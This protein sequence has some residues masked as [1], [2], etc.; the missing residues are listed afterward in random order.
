MYTVNIIDCPKSP[1][2]GVLGSEKHAAGEKKSYNLDFTFDTP[3]VLL[4][5]Q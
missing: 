3:S 5:S 1:H 2:S 4:R